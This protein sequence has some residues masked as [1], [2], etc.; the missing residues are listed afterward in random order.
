MQ[1]VTSFTGVSFNGH[2]SLTVETI[3]IIFFSQ[4]PR[5]W[6]GCNVLYLPHKTWTF[7]GSSKTTAGTRHIS[8]PREE[9]QNV[10]TTNSLKIWFIS[11][12]SGGETSIWR[13]SDKPQ[14]DMSALLHIL[15][16]IRKI[17]R[18]GDPI[19][20]RVVSFSKDIFWRCDIP[21]S[22]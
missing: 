13:L 21:S 5:V 1:F 9:P 3:F 20:A 12:W 15:C 2:R 11:V 8:H 14:Q 7:S 6:S 10:M 16:V 17:Q 22:Q 4:T 19:L 18:E